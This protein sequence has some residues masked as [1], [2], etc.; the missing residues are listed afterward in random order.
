MDMNS[1]PRRSFRRPAFCMLAAVTMVTALSGC[2]IQT[3]PPTPDPVT[4]SLANRTNRTLTPGF[5]RSGTARTASQLFVGSNLFTQYGDG[6]QFPELAINEFY[7]VT[8][9]CANIETF[10]VRGST[11]FNPVSVELT[12]YDGEV[13]NRLDENFACGDSILI[14]YDIVDGEITVEVE[15]N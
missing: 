2:I 13:F 9:D 15:I 4:V 3:A 8:I 1:A 12:T 6:R 10:G 14:I 11:A 5:Y 7:T